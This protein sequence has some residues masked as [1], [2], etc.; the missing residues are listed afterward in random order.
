M[1]T[2]RR[3]RRPRDMALRATL[4]DATRRDATLL[5]ALL[6][7]RP[8]KHTTHV[9]RLIHYIYIQTA[10]TY[11][12]ISLSLCVY[13]YIYIYIHSIIFYMI[14]N[15]PPPPPAP[16]IFPAGSP[17]GVP[18]PPPHRDCAP[19]DAYSCSPRQHTIST[20]RDSRV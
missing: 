12:Y 9:P 15:T 20:A 3:H 10:Y 19:W 17:L 5:G 11:L 18:R 13:I 7:R 14:V 4:R 8:P 2:R 16:V 1:G 6:G